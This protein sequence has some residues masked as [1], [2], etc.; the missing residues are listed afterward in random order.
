[1]KINFVLKFSEHQVVSCNG[2]MLTGNNTALVIPG[3][4]E[5]TAARSHHLFLLCKCA[6]LSKNIYLIYDFSSSVQPAPG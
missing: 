5:E 6:V 1:M 4:G 3:Y 2:A